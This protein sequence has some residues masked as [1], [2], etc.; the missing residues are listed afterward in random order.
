MET[1]TFDKHDETDIALA[2]TV[3]KCGHMT[4][5]QAGGGTCPAAGTLAARLR[6]VAPLVRGHVSKAC[7]ECERLAPYRSLAAYL[8]AAE[9]NRPKSIP[10]AWA[11]EPGASS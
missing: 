5:R 10:L 3:L 1:I 11:V 7:A 6:A 8:A 2:V 9:T 4:V